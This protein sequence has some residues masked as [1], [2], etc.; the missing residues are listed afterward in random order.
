MV[1]NEE[2]EMKE[3]VAVSLKNQGR[4]CYA[5]RRRLPNGIGYQKRTI[6]RRI[7]RK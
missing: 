7:R 3:A 5:S 4:N 2:E 1:V 6:G